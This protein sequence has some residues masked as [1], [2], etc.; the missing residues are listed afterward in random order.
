[1]GFISLEQS[2]NLFW[3]G[4]YT[5]RVYLTL[6]YLEK[7]FDTLIDKDP[8]AY[9][10]YC[11]SLNIPNVY[12][13]SMDFMSNYLFDKKNPDSVYANLSRAYDNGIILRNSISSNCL[14][15]IQMSLDTLEEGK[16]SNSYGLLN[17]KIID[18]LLAFWGGIDEFVGT[19]SERHLIK[20]GRYLERLDMQLRLGAPW[21]EIEITL[22]KMERRLKGAQA[23]YDVL[24]VQTILGYSRTR[25]MDP[26]TRLV[27][28]NMAQVIVSHQE[29]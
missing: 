16:I 27:A 11:D 20:A 29:N 9:I 3:L 7:L 24:K 14:A 2:E 26:D 6:T 23:Q 13:D 1:M 8:Q 12:E 4:R 5:E 22:G 15:Y 19:S 10:A 21:E 18:Y 25:P 28:L 17:Q